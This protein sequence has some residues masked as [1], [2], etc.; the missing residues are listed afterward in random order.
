MK[1][2]GISFIGAIGLFVLVSVG[3]AAI[4]PL[5]VLPDW[6]L[7]VTACVIAV[8]TWGVALTWLIT[9]RKRWGKSRER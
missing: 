2:I 6:I 4:Y 8:L 1:K 9:M 5:G 7:W 3:S